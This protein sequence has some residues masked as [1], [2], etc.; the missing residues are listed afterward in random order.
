MR[1][2][3]IQ[4]TTDVDN[5]SATNFTF[6]VTDGTTTRYTAATAITI[7]GAT[8]TAMAIAFET[9]LTCASGDY[10]KCGVF[11]G[12]GNTEFIFSLYGRYVE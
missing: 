7:A 4:I 8:P 5:I 10:V 12:N 9:P 2:D 3:G 11:A 1:F 6:Y